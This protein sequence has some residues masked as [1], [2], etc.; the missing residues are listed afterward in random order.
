VIQ[1][2][3]RTGEEGLI[4]GS[5]RTWRRWTWRLLRDV[6][7]LLRLQLARGVKGGMLSR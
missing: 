1:A 2:F 5:R 4:A 6:T 7:E 3:L